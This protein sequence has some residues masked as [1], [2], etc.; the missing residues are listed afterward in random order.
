M[1]QLNIRS[2]GIEAIVAELK[3]SESQ[4]KIALKR[5]LNKMAKW[6][7]TRTVRGLSSELALTQKILRR[8][9]KKS[10]IVQSDSGFSIRLFYG[11]FVAQRFKR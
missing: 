9:L 11:G 6:M 7:S 10:N 5:T 8:R 4:A 3:P 2:E 1:I